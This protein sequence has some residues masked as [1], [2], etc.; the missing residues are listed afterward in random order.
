VE[1][2]GGGGGGGGGGAVVHKVC[3]I[4]GTAKRVSKPLSP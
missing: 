4:V 3:S 1:S 2:E